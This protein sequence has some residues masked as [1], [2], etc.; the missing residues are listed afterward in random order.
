MGDCDALY[1]PGDKVERA[2]GS[3]TFRGVVL[4]SFM[5][6]LGRRLYAVEHRSER[7]LVHV[8]READLKPSPED[9]G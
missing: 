7:G 6:T 1:I 9:N 2:N 5:T 3:Y 8:F 4:A